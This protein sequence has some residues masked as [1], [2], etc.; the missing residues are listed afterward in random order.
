M[1]R[2]SSNATP[3]SSL[4]STETTMWGGVVTRSQF[5]QTISNLW[6]LNEVPEVPVENLVV[7]EEDSTRRLSIAREKEIASNLAF[8]S[9]TSDNSLKVM[10]V[11]VEENNNGEGVT[12]R[13]ASNTG[14]LSAVTSG[15]TMLATILEQAARRGR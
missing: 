13:I 8:L 4:R 5:Q 9:A 14:D 10:A 11:C 2:P 3:I 1:T 7:L 6:E 12:I 15:F